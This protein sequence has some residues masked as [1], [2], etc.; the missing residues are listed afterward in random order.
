[1]LAVGSYD[2]KLI[3]LNI[4]WLLIL[5]E[6]CTTKGAAKDKGMDVP[7]IVSDYRN[8]A[9]VLSKGVPNVLS[10]SNHFAQYASIGTI[11]VPACNGKST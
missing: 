6:A 7:E 1:M 3:L 5:G 11:V 8:V 2:G 4:D 10:L 9:R